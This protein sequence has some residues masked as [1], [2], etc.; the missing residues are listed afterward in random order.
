M[1]FVHLEPRPPSSEQ[2]NKPHFCTKQCQH[3]Q[4]SV[5]GLLWKL[6]A[7]N[8]ISSVQGK[9]VAC[10]H[11]IQ[12]KLV[13]TGIVINILKRKKSR[14]HQVE[15]PCGLKTDLL[16]WLMVNSVLHLHE[17]WVQTNAEEILSV[18]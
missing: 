3:C 15:V 18:N 12:I 7:S 6:M 5:N 16:F 4:K 11:I 10:F 1:Y 2:R 13:H 14:R 8:Q 9:S 17:F